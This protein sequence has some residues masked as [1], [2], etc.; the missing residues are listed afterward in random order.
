MSSFLRRAG[1]AVALV[2]M[3]YVFGIVI[4][5]FTYAMMAIGQLRVRGLWRLIR[6]RRGGVLVIANHPSIQET[7]AIPALFVPLSL[8]MP[9]RLPYSTPDKRNFS[10]RWFW[11]WARVRM[12]PIP[13][14][15]KGNGN[16]RAMAESVDEIVRLL[17]GGATVILFPEGG[18]TQSGDGQVAV[19]GTSIRARP[20]KGAGLG[21]ILERVPDVLVMVLAVQRAEDRRVD[22]KGRPDFWR[23][24]RILVS[25]RPFRL[26]EGVDRDE[27]CQFVQEEFFVV[28]SQAA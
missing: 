7:I 12:V 3:V 22:I 15:K 24:M 23:T 6:P 5:A 16:G 9:W 25:L 1:R 26:M 11:A 21:R 17:R 8:L 4:G 10:D 28:A 18:R 2:L 19:P 20:F 14:A 13:R 27:A